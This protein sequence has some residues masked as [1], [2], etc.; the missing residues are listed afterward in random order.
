MKIGCC[1]FATSFERYVRALDVVEVQQTFYKPPKP[2]TA[3]RWREKA[4]SIKREFEFTVKAFQVITH[5]PTSPTYRKAKLE[6][7]GDVGFFNPVKEVFEAWEKTKEIAEILRAD[8]ILFQTPSSFKMTGENL[9]K[10]DEFFSSIEGGFTFIWEPRDYSERLAEFVEVLKRHGI[11]ECVDPLVSQPCLEQEIN[12]FRLHGT[13][14]GKRI[15]YSHTYTDEEL[16]EL[17]RRARK[18]SNPYVMFNNKT[19][20]QDAL[21]F[22][23]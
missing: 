21:R 20:F 19:M 11:I 15:I 18:F 8:K 9:K 23:S 5:P 13:Y 10:V 16:F 14:E 22:K 2:E 6:V 4:D 1:G 7:G 3:E 17:R 12:Y